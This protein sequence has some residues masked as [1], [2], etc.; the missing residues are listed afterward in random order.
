MAYSAWL[1]VGDDHTN[2]FPDVRATALDCLVAAIFEL[3]LLRA[4]GVHAIY[5]L[6]ALVA[7]FDG[8]RS[9]QSAAP[10]S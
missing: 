6:L 2:E 7:A 8:A 3:S 4:W 1:C 9:E 5:L 10:Q